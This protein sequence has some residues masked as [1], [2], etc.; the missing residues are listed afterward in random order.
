M[1]LGDLRKR[2][3]NFTQLMKPSKKTYDPKKYPP[4]A[5]VRFSTD[6]KAAMMRLANDGETY[7]QVI[8]R[9]CKEFAAARGRELPVK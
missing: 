2:A 7:S 6:F 9:A 4:G 5:S 1:W 3:Q 8:R